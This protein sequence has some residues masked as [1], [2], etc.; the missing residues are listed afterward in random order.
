MEGYSSVHPPIGLCDKVVTQ[1]SGNGGVSDKSTRVR[2]PRVVWI[3][4][5]PGCWACS[6][7]D[8]RD[9]PDTCM[10][11]TVGCSASIDHLA[12]IACVREDISLASY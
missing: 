4:H 10:H 1:T 3:G 8:E 6:A 11:A 7:L 2:R 5:T 9:S 12:R